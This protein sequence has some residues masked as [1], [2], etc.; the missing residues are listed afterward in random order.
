MIFFMARTI[1]PL[2]IV[3]KYY[4]KGAKT[5]GTLCVSAVNKKQADKVILFQIQSW[6]VLINLKCMVMI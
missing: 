1:F 5:Q 3:I 6:I 4:R 2:S